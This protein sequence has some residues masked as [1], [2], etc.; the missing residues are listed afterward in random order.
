MRQRLRSDRGASAV[1]FALVLPLLL[2]L[3]VGIAEFGRAYNVQIS[4]SAAAREGVRVAA[5][6]TKDNPV[7][8]AQNRTQDTLFASSIS[9]SDVSVEFGQFTV[10]NTFEPTPG[11]TRCATNLVAQVKVTHNF[12]M[13]TGLLGEGFELDGTGVMRCGG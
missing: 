6:S 9:Q 3:V 4:L 11:A 1:E 5:I 7:P 8:E 13:L 10:E 12:T 2:L